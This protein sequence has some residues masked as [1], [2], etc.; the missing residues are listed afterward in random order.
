MA[1]NESDGK[2][3]FLGGGRVGGYAA[4]L[5]VLVLL[6]CGG[7][8]ILRDRSPETGTARPV[9]P[10]TMGSQQATAAPADP[11]DPADPVEPVETQIPTEAP[12]TTWILLGSVALPTVSGVG[13]AVI[14]GMVASGYQ[15]SPTGALLAVANA[16][17]RLPLSGD[18][19]WEAVTDAVVAPGAAG[20]AWRDLRGGI[21]TGPTNLTGDYSQ[22]TGFQFLS[23]ADSEAVIQLVTVDNNGTLQM[24]AYRVRWVEEDWK[25][26]PADSGKLTVNS[27]ILSSLNG[28]V[29]WKGVS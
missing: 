6:L 26:V 9:Q 15:H 7:Y 20:D 16:S 1:D 18:E 29:V 22:I 23:Y 3:L 12:D 19:D 13:P 8:L 10:P 17:Y 28:F 2:K 25:F 4:I 24:A 21:T 14:D 27:Q 11:V 5:F